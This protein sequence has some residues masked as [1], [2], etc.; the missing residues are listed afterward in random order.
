VGGGGGGEK[1]GRGRLGNSRY[2]VVFSSGFSNLKKPVPFYRL[3]IS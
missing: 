3:G 1:R 2:D